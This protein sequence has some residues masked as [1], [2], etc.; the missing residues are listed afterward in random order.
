MSYTHYY[1][2]SG[3][4]HGAYPLIMGTRLDVLLFG[5]EQEILQMSWNE[6][7]EEIKHLEALLNRFDPLSEVSFINKKAV[8]EAVP[9]SEE[10]WEILLDCKKYYTLTQGYFDITL[11]GFHNIR[12]LEKDRSVSL[13]QNISLD[14]GGYAK[15]YALKRIREIL[16]G[17]D[18]KRAFV[19]FGNSSI[20]G[21]GTHPHGRNWPVGIQ[22]PYHPTEQVGSIG[23]KDNALS[24]S[25]NMPTHPK[26]L[27]DPFAH[28]YREEHKLVSVV[29]AN[30]V[31]A[32]VLSTALFLMDEGTMEKTI[33]EFTI[34]DIIIFKDHE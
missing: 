27:F 11:A 23:L 13:K 12:L 19:N 18:I 3:M 16:A 21:M 28:T 25:G 7:L 24:T 33:K 20:L 8:S 14:F 9:V 26:H 17:R 5:Q 15:G 31:D 32:E 4:F 30:P 10:L 1:Q 6:L 34:D 29:T 2:S 22:N